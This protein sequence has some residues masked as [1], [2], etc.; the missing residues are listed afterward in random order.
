MDKTS[1]NQRGIAFEEKVSVALENLRFL[2]PQLVQVRRWPVVK[3]HNGVELRPDF[4][5]IYMQPPHRN[6]RLIECQ[7]RNK[8]SHDVVN[9]ILRMKGGHSPRN[10][11]ILVYEDPQYLSTAVREDLDSAGILHYSY[12]EFLLFLV[13]LGASLRLTAPL[14]EAN[15]AGKLPEFLQ[16]DPA[17]QRFVRLSDLSDAFPSQV[18]HKDEGMLGSAP[19][20]WK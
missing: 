14:E 5:L 4:E 1:G 16:S 8:S 18:K 12:Q 6:L 9:K 11:F 2:C 7:S 15:A 19:P 3:L 20:R 17:L 10:R 13:E